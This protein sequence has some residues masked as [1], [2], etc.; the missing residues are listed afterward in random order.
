MDPRIIEIGQSL[1][2]ASQQEDTSARG[3]VTELFPF[4]FT[5]ARR[6]SA[7]SI[8]RCLKEAHNVKISA[9][10]ISR[11]LKE[12][13]KHL[14]PFAEEVEPQARLFASCHGEDLET[15]LENQE[16]FQILSEQPPTIA[17]NSKEEQAAMYD[18]YRCAAGFIRDNW[19]GLDS[20]V[21]SVVSTIIANTEEPEAENA[22]EPK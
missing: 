15:I 8:S 5:A 9:V 6:M 16:A 2:D 20:E 11:A 19:Y 14:E 10:T 21:R 22:E 1:V 4:I 17:G 18:D 12:P 7:R 13:K 3:L